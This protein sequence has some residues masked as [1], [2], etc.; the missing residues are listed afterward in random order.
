ML[1]TLHLQEAHAMSRVRCLYCDAPNDAVQSA[2]FCENCGKKLPP[3][4]LAH[5]RHAPVLHERPHTLT[6]DLERTPRQQA[7][8]WLFTAALVNLVGCGALV[9]LGSLL[10]P[11]DH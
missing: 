4:S 6:P 7:S 5:E 9:V 8:A 11:R 10:V 3:A 2:G 1:R